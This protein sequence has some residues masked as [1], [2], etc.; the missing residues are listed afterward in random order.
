MPPL[1]RESGSALRPS[2]RERYQSLLKPL[3]IVFVAALLALAFAHLG[4]EVVEGDTRFFDMQLLRGAQSLR[5]AHPWLAEV[6]RDLSGLGST[7]VLALFTVATTGYLALISARTS[8]FLVATSVISGSILV[9]V[10][11]AA[12]GRLRP[13]AAYAE[14]SVAG[15][16]FPSGHASMS[17]IVFL[18][19]GSLLASTHSRPAERIYILGT[20]VLMTLLVGLSR[21]ALG[22][23]WATDVLGGWA[24]GAAWAGLWLVLAR[25]VARRGD[26]NPVS[27]T[28][29]SEHNKR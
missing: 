4:S 26:A 3:F 19:L 24:F 7:T 6:M 13:D 22:V 17:A 29:G 8:A 2:Q 5:A 14:L 21:V 10:F 11:K 1:P 27:R 15:L 9:S 20:A 16:S 18:T 28:G 25:H 23:H 12:F